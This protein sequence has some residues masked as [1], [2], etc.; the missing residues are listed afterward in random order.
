MLDME[1]VYLIRPLTGS[2]HQ[3]ELLGTVIG[4]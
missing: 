3:S 4:Y 1:Q 2:G